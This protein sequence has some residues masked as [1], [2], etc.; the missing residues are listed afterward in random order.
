MLAFGREAAMPVCE[1][2]DCF[3]PAAPGGRK[4]WAHYKQAKRT[5]GVRP[6]VEGPPAARLAEGARA[7]L[8][9]A[10]INLRDSCSE[11]DGAY[12][13]SEQEFWDAFRAAARVGADVV[14]L[15]NPGRKMP[16]R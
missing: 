16:R 4:C 14:A 10:A 2:D 3:R 9:A 7:R 5:G 1:V 6:I 15:S 13:A 11:D 12:A 8:F